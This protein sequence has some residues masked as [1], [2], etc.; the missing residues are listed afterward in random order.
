M[1]HWNRQ[2]CVSIV[3]CTTKTSWSHWGKVLRKVWVGLTLQKYLP[4]GKIH[5][6]MWVFWKSSV[7]G[8]A[9]GKNGLQYL[10]LSFFQELLIECI[11][12]GYEVL[13]YFP[14]LLGCLVTYTDDNK[15]NSGRLCIFNSSH[16]LETPTNIENREKIKN[17]K[18]VVLSKHM[19]Q[20]TSVFCVIMYVFWSKSCISWNYYWSRFPFASPLHLD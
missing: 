9:P 7:L 12:R 3:S 10:I 20:I 13:H 17:I 4:E 15:E 8:C 2:N 16:P 11:V 1:E 18:N 19:K 6:L 5:E 14:V